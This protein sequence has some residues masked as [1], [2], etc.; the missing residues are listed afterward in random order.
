MWWV[1]LRIANNTCRE[2]FPVVRS[3]AKSMEAKEHMEAKGQCV[4]KPR[5]KRG[6]TS[7]S[8]KFHS[9][10]FLL[11]KITRRWDEPQWGQ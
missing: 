7:T 9:T 2:K 11:E 10:S 1:R 5:P 6:H 3:T 8:R 4:K